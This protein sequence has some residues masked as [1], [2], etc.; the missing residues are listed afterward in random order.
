MRP[1]V[2][3]AYSRML[4][5][6]EAEEALAT[7]AQTAAGSGCMQEKD[8]RNYFRALR[9]AANGGK[10]EPVQKATVASL[11]QIGIQVTTVP[12]K[13][14]TSQEGGDTPSPSS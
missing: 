1:A 2:L 5:I 4:P 10:R 7:V 3:Q 8:Q 11:A 6:L 12:P 13:S 9:Q 14:E